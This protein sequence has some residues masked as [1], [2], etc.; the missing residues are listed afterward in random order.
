L[1]VPTSVSSNRE[2]MASSRDTAASSIVP[3]FSTAAAQGCKRCCRWLHLH[4]E[5][6]AGRPTSEAA[7]DAQGI[8]E[9]TQLSPPA[10]PLCSWAVGGG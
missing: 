4:R 3:R 6:D 10:L 8:A 2:V 1:S 9:Q 5:R 7:K